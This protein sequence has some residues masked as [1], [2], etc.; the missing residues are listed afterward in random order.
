MGHEH[1]NHYHR[2]AGSEMFI[3]R[4]HQNYCHR[5]ARSEMFIELR[6]QFTLQAPLGAECF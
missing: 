3:D 6:L 1:Q 2:S 4:K 5:A